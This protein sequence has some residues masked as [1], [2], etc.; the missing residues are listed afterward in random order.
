MLGV[1]YLRLRLSAG[2]RKHEYAYDMHASS[3]VCM[4]VSV[5]VFILGYKFA[6]QAHAEDRGCSSL[7]IGLCGRCGFLAS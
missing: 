6:V 3:H 2:V 1:A 4:R 5:S 7:F